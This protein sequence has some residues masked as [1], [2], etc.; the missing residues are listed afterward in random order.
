MNNFENFSNRLK[1]ARQ[2]AGLGQEQLAQELHVSGG[3]VGNWEAGPKLPT[4]ENL[5]K[6][7]D[8]LGVSTAWLIYGEKSGEDPLAAGASPRDPGRMKHSRTEDAAELAASTRHKIQAH[9]EKVIEC[10]D[11]DRPRLAWL[12]CEVEDKFP[13]KKFTKEKSE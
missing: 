6:I 12:L 11:G 13:L 9:I 8:V 10:I 2:L 3:A 5:G 1:A 7:A 4:A